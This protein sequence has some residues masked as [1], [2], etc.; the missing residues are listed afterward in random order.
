MPLQH[1]L[2]ESCLRHTSKCLFAFSI[3]FIICINKYITVGTKGTKPIPKKKAIID[4]MVDSFD[5]N[6]KKRIIYIIVHAINP[7]KPNFASLYFPSASPI[8]FSQFSS[9]S[10]CLFLLFFYIYFAQAYKYLKLFL[11]VLQN[12]LKDLLLY[13]LYQDILY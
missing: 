3:S 4:P 2:F 7:N 10:A 9:S 1:R 8:N 11:F 5:F 6:I 13:I 12:L